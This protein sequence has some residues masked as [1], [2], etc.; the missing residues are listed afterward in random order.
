MLKNYLTIAI[1]NLWRHRV[2]SAINL[3]GLAVGMSSFLLIFSYVS[4]ERSYDKFNPK[5]DR[6]YRLICDTRTQTELLPTGLSSGPAGPSIKANFPE[7][8]T[9]ARISYQNG[10]LEHGE[11]RFQENNIIAA[12]STLFDIFAFPLLKGD[13]KTALRDPFSVV[14]SEAGAQKYFGSADPMGQPLLVDHKY[15]FRVTGVMKNIPDNASFHS[16][17]FFSMTSF[18]DHLYG[19]WD[20]NWGNF[21]WFTFLLLR[22]GADP[23]RLEARLPPFVKEKAADVEKATGMSYTYHLQPLKKIHLGP[24]LNNYGIG[25]PTGS[26]SNTDVFAIVGVFLLLIASINFVNLATARAA[27]RAREVGIRKAIGAV[28]GQLTLQFLGESI[29]LCLLAFVL[30]IALCNALHPLFGILLGK[31]IPLQAFG[32]GS[33]VALLLGIAIGI[34]VIAGIYP[35]LVL[36]GFNPVAVLK[37][38]FGSSRKGLRLRE[39]L[40]VFQFVIST[41]LIIGTIV[42][43]NQLRYMQDQELGFNKNQEIAINYHGDSAVRVN[44]EPLRH[45]LSAIPGVKAVAYSN[46]VPGNSPTNWFLRIA[47]PQGDMQGANL[48]FYVVDFDFFP[49]YGI[50]MAAGRTFSRDFSTD[51]TKALILNEAAARSLGYAD[52]TKAVG[53][54]F[55]MW[56]VDG[57]IIGVARDFHYRSLQEAIQ[58]LAFRVMDQ[59]WYSMISVRITGDHIPQTVA[60]LGHRWQQLVPGRPFEYSFVDDDF[61]KLYASEDR[62]QRVFL[63]FGL[64]AIFI[65]CLGLL[66]LAAYSTF[67]RTKEIGIRKVLG[68]SVSTIVALLSKEFLRLVVIALVIASPVAW[69]AMHQWLQDFAYRTPIAWW[70]FPLAASAAVI[71]TLVTVG[72]HSIRAAVAD[73]VESLRTE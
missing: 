72:F 40:V 17:C 65:S 7:V 53:R 71:I 58:P 45:E 60:A 43:Y 26:K 10:L 35:A 22:P 18:V 27:E 66:G 32:A 70:V 24:T 29:L 63:Y 67:Q 38:R 30:A 20:H 69:F 42:V 23:T 34:G 51:S 39:V 37:G 16:D 55:N 21:G 9:E 4:F 49:H 48:N 13:P 64:L 52:P 5:A 2:F 6:I 62:F 73:P 3:L 1:R 59:G 36:S 25:E 11:K 28:R 41:A 57:T 8:E 19:N 33:Y 12:D 68:A 46:Y 61:A 44:T 47:N 14:L 50:R 15:V 56:G 31:D 54:K